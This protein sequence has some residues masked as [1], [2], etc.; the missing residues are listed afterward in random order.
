MNDLGYNQ[1]DLKMSCVESRMSNYGSEESPPQKKR[2]N[3]KASPRWWWS[4]PDAVALS[5]VARLT[6]LDHAA[7]S[8]VSKRHRSLVASPELCRARSLIGCTEASLYVCLNIM[9]DPNPSWFVLTRNRQLR[10][11]PSNPYQPLRSSSSS[12]LVVDWGIYVIG[13]IVNGNP[14]RDVW[15]L[16]CYSHTWHPVPNDWCAIGDLLFCRGTRGRILWCEPDELDWKEVKGLE[17]LQESFFCGLRHVMDY[18]KKVYEPCKPTERKVKYDISK[19]SCNSS[20]NIVI[21][22]NTQ[23]EYPEGLELKSA[24][25][26]LERHQE[27]EIW[28]KIEWSASTYNFWLHSDIN[29]NSSLAISGSKDGSVHIENIVTGKFSPS[30]ATIL[31][32]ATRGMDKKLVIWDLQHSTPRFICDHAVPSVWSESVPVFNNLKSLAVKS[33]KDRGWPAIPA[34]LRNCPHLQTL[35][36][37]GLVH[38]VTDKC[39]DVCDC[40]SREDKG[41]SL[42]RCPVKVVKIHGFQGTMKEVATIQHFFG[43]FSISGGDGGGLL[44]EE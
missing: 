5:I 7:L 28:G 26:S 39:G 41:F 1:S 27:S 8:L 4:L 14:T 25:I 30:S 23:L 10:Q 9:P 2:R 35:V 43:V 44:C 42:T 6:R 12:F 15:F 16:D 36:V 24:E 40:I 20:G 11:I 38:H 29:S 21:F 33:D 19:L 32:A 3:E 31:M 34:L 17:E 13:G 18:G 22:W 37:K